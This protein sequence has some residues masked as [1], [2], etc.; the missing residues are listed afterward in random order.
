MR[1]DPGGAVLEPGGDL[2]RARHVACP[3]GGCETVIGIIG[4]RH[5][6]VG[7]TEASHGNH[8]TEHL[9][10]DDLVVL[11]RTG[12]DGGL[13]EETRTRHDLATGDD[14]HVLHRGRAI[15]EPRHALALARGDDRPQFRRLVLR[16]ADGQRTG[17]R[18]EIGHE[19]VVDAGTGVHPA[20]RRAV[21]TGVVVAEGAQTAHD[22]ID[23]GVV[24]DDDRCLAAQFEVGTLQSRNG[25]LQHG[26][27]RGN[28][29]RDGHHRDL[30]MRDE[31]LADD[32]TAPVDDVDDALGEDLRADPRELERR[33]RREFR[34]LEHKRVARCQ[35]GRD[36]PRGHHQRVVPR[37]DLCDHT[38]GVAADHARVAG[39][40]LLGRRARQAARRPCEIAEHV[41]HRRQFVRGNPRERLA[42][43]E[44]LETGEL[45]RVV[46]DALCQ[47]KQQRGALRRR[48]LTPFLEGPGRRGDG[49]IHLMRGRLRDRRERAAGRGIQYRQALPCPIHEL[50]ANQQLR[51][52]R[53]TLPR[54]FVY[55]P[56]RVTSRC[57]PHPGYPS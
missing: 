20:G 38:D 24:E 13:V 56:G 47:A 53:S 45:R 36:L 1:I 57:P 33:E 31:G 48:R 21:L 26:L 40:V 35:R 46:L 52:H 14:F 28:A 22:G 23:V 50:A 27:P 9:L 2:H 10:A 44:R 15:D 41:R 39:Q 42:A 25:R 3:Y 17:R 8:R 32:R 12:N 51:I 43:V 6:V 30:R 55:E 29:A 5:R 19:L 18:T 49:G 34:G 11:Q 4:P 7:V 37:G 16:C 54:C